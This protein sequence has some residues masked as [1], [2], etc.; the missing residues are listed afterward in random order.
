MRLF[1]ATL[2]ALCL[3]AAVAQN[4]ELGGLLVE[5]IS[6]R[7]AQRQLGEAAD[8]KIEGTSGKLFKGEVVRQF[9]G[10][11]LF[12]DVS[13]KDLAKRTK[14]AAS[15]S[16]LKHV[17]DRRCSQWAVVTTINEPTEAVQRQAMEEDWCLVVIGDRKGPREYPLPQAANW[18]VFLDDK[19]Q[20]TFAG[21]HPLGK[22]LPWNHF[23]RKNLGFVFA[24][25]HGAQAVFD[26]DDDNMLLDLPPAAGATGGHGHMRGSL[27]A[28]ATGHAHPIHGRKLPNAPNTVAHSHSASASSKDKAHG[29]SSGSHEHKAAEAKASPLVPPAAT[30]AA[31]ASS[32]AAAEQA[33][34]PS[35][36]AAKRVLVLPGSGH[37]EG[38]YH[39]NVPFAYNFSLLNPYPLMG[40]TAHPAW[41][42]G[43]PLHLLKA[44]YH[45]YSST[46]TSAVAAPLSSPHAASN[47]FVLNK[48]AVP[49]A[50]VGV[51]QYLANHDPDVDAIYRLVQPLPLNFQL[52]QHP[53]LL[54]LFNANREQV[55]C[56]YN[57][58][59]T[60]HTRAALW[61]L[62]LPITVHGR[63]SDIWRSY[64]A[65]RLMAD[66]DLA[67]VF[68]PPLVVQFRN[69]HNYLA[70]FDSEGPLYL[71][72]GT[73]VEQLAAWHSCAE[74]LPERMESLWIMLYERGYVQQADVA[75]LQAWLATL[76]E[77]QYAFPEVKHSHPS[78]HK[79]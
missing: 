21:D 51:V 13:A 75:L 22:L 66:V 24:I 43:Y 9:D 60:L 57:A 34:K 14:D 71:Q 15:S 39:V 8:T 1:L 44:T 65:Q 4:F 36:A 50:S 45:H 29:S 40:A 63:V 26:F 42:R 33:A 23:G 55:F 73:L 11:R 67:V 74:T 72:A 16:R 52:R 5:S 32:A 79:K 41:P 19:A 30:A 64:F 59:A 47:S 68:H 49:A 38:L 25:L 2:S 54:P 3:W 10:T 35:P 20:E 62:L 53:L 37:S 7:I 56:P 77:L 61:T 46:P 48:V 12:K 17:S 31:P 18:T 78:C 69:S 27:G 28:N 70:D 58:Q 76:L 6:H